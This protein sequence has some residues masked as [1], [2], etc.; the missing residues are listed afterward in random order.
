M[1]VKRFAKF[2]VAATCALASVAL[3]QN[4]AHA[5]D[6]FIWSI[7][8]TTGKPYAQNGFISGLDFTLWVLAENYVRNGHSTQ[9]RSWSVPLMGVSNVILT[10]T[11]ASVDTLINAYGAVA[12]CDVGAKARLRV[13]NE[14]GN[15]FF[16]GNQG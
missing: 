3:G 14:S 12:F 4:N 10:G 11:N 6:G 2:I 16:F 9:T 5:T 7:P 1:T 8:A 13:Y 15:A